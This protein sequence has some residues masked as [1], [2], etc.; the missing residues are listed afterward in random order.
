MRSIMRRE[1]AVMVDLCCATIALVWIRAPPS[2]SLVL[3]QSEAIA[4]G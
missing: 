1:A 2:F 4:T 3:C